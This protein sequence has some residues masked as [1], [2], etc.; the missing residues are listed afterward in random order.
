MPP[1]KWVRIASVTVER[2][3]VGMP[4]NPNLIPTVTVDKNGRTTTVHRK[5]NVSVSNTA[6]PAPAIGEDTARDRILVNHVL[7]LITSLVGRQDVNASKLVPLKT[8]L[9]YFKTSFLQ[10]LELYL[11]CDH[12]TSLGVAQQVVNGEFAEIIDETIYYHQRIGGTDY[13]D[14]AALVRSLAH[15]DPLSIYNDLSKIDEPIRKQCEALIKATSVIDSESGTA[16]GAEEHPL[17]YAPADY[18]RQM[19]IIKNQGLVKLIMDNPDDAKHIAHIVVKHN[20][21]DQNSILGIMRGIIPALAEG[22]L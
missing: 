6:L 14:S 15:Y 10:R 22:S 13:W 16:P 18:D 3:F 8:S 20:T 11:Q 17:E 5:P 21:T 12:A 9:N 2:Y 4:L 19:R 1:T 7:A